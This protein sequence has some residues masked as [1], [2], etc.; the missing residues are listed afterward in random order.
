VSIEPDTKDWT[1]VL[2]EPCPDCGYDARRVERAAIGALVRDDASGWVAVL[3]LPDAAERPDPATW[4]PLEYACHVRDVHRVFAERLTLMLTQDEPTF[5]NWD[6]DET[7][8][9]ER[10]AEQ[11]PAAV[12]RELPLT[13]EALAAAYDAVPDGA[14]ERRGLRSNGSEFTVDSL[15]RYLLH[16]L[17]HHAWDVRESASRATAA[18]YDAYAGDF[19]TS[20]DTMVDHVLAEVEWLAAQV[21]AGAVLE[22]GSGGG[23]DALALERSGLTVRRTDVSQGFVDLLRE[24]G[25]AAVR[26]DP[27][28]D[29][30]GG[31]WDAVWANASLLHVARYDLATVLGRL[32]GATRVGGALAMTL[33][34][35]DGEG[36]STHGSVGAPRRF[37]YWREDA[38]RAVL[39]G[40]GWSAEVTHRVGHRDQPWLTI[41]AS[42]GGG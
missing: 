4:S 36:W 41:R 29:D 7:A 22:I 39:E 30:L 18:A 42:R 31:P 37:T 19:A 21:P 26:L 16:D 9:A 8:L 6:Q 12:A 15:G 20:T 24:R 34:E 35:G 40:A 2:S 23:R 13:A 1:W 3:A 28:H 25:H 14:W 27:L 10:Y 5:A 38:V 11:D 17:V 32:A 33:K